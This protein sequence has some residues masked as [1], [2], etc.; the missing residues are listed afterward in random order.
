MKFR[1]S[2]GVL[3]ALAACVVY[4]QAEKAHINGVAADPS[5]TTI[6]GAEVRDRST[7]NSISLLLNGQ[8]E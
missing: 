7:A 5:G 4:G 2:L 8:S 3:L 6:P 1:K